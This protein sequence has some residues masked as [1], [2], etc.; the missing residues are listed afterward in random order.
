MTRLLLAAAAATAA[1]LFAAATSV[2]GSEPCVPEP[3][4]TGYSEQI[5]PDAAAVVAGEPVKL[6]SIDAVLE[7][8]RRSYVRQKRVFPA[9]GT[10][11]YRALQKLALAF[12]IRRVE[13]DQVA[14]QLGIE[15]TPAQIERRLTQIKKQFFGGSE[16]R[17]QAE[18]RKNGLTEEQVREDIR[19]QLVSERLYDQVTS[20]V[21]VSEAEVEAYYRDHLDQYRQPERR[22]VRH[23]LVKGLELANRL[24]RELK[25]GASFAALARKYS[26]DPGSKG[27]GGRLLIARGQ[28]VPAFDR[29]A[30]ALKTGE[31]SMPV[32]TQYGW[33]LIQALGDIRP[34]SQQ[35]LAEVHDVIAQ[36]LR[37]QQRTAAITGWQFA[38]ERNWRPTIFYARGFKP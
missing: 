22:A 25:A 26:L 5:P 18:L 4:P 6:A 17:F 10:R 8:A 21:E 11:E 30:F 9:K 19:A 27:Q 35:S 28:T 33:H 14:V 24:Y 34:A 32:K 16:K 3:T 37:V 2:A 13:Y 23:I 15:I 7:Q 38:L 12:L 31:L 1:C 36:Q 20:C 29:A